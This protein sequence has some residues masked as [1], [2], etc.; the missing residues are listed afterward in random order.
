M[1]RL[2]Y[3]T[4]RRGAMGQDDVGR[5]GNQLGR[6]STN[7]VGVA[8][9]PANFELHVISNCPAQQ[10]QS[11]SRTNSAAISAL[12]SGRPS[13]Q[14]YSIAMV[15]P[16]TQPSSRSR[17]T[18]AA[19]Q[20]LKTD[21]FAP[22]KPI[23]GSFSACGYAATGHVVADQEIASSHCLPRGLGPRQLSDYSSDLRPAE[24]GLTVIL[25]GNN[26]QGRMSA[27]GHKRTFCYKIF[28]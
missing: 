4:S 9:S 13:D 21:A 11:L 26:P 22:M 20:G 27:L 2:Q 18:K 7:V 5:E 15:R 3:P 12:R 28:Q 14:R 10:R 6:V 25:R 8:S 1:G 24:W 17:P 19:V 23:L 16:S